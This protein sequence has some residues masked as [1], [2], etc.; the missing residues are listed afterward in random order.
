M[1]CGIGVQ[2]HDAI[3]VGLNGETLNKSECPVL[4]HDPFTKRCDAGPCVTNWFITE[5]SQVKIFDF[6]QALKS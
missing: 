3:C 5:W 2:T 1:K 6:L 4:K